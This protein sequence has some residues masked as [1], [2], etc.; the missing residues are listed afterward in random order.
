[1]AQLSRRDFVKIAAGAAAVAGGGALT[2]KLFDKAEKGRPAVEGKKAASNKIDYTRARAIPTVCFGCTTHCGCI[3]WVQD[4]RVRRIDG[5]PFDINTRGKICSKAQ[6]MIQYTYYPER[7]LY[8]I[9]RVGKRGEGKW[10]RISWDEALAEIAGRMK[11]TRESGHPERFIFHYGRDKT[12]GFT[13]RFTNAYGTPNRL[14][15][16]SICSSN[17]RA[18]LMSF[19]GRDFEWETQ[20]FANSKYIVNF[21]GNPMEAYQGGIFMMGRM[22]DAIVDNGCKMVTFE[23]RPSAT[24]SVSTEYYP[25]APGS[26]GAIAA[27]MGNVIIQEG[28]A[29]RKFWDRWA[30]Y[31][32]DKIAAHLEQYTPEWAEK[33]SELP[34]DV[35]RR[36]AIEFARAA[37]AA[38]T[39]SNR[40]SAK[41]YNG[42]Q[43]DRLIRLLDVL[44]GSVGKPGG[45]TLSTVRGWNGKRYGQWGL[46]AVGQP[47]P[48]PPGV[49]A[50]TP[51][52]PQFDDLPQDVKDRWDEFPDKWKKKYVGELATPMDYPLSFHWYGM[53]VGQLVQDYIKRGRHKVEVYMSYVYG[54][55]YGYPEAKVCREVMKDET[56][57][58]FHVAIDIGYGEHSSL[59]DM[60]LPEATSL[61]RWD[62][63]SQNS[64]ALIPY[65]GVRQPLVKP[66]GQARPLQD[67]L[68]ELAVR[69]GGGM[70]KYFDYESTEEFYKAWYKNVP[71][72]WPEFLKRGFWH[73]DTR[74]KDYELYE[75][76]VPEAEMAGAHVDD[77]TG[78]IYKQ[79]KRGREVAIG[80]MMGDRPVRGFPTPTRKIQIYD[81]VWQEAARFVGLPRGDLSG[82]VIPTWMPVPEHLTMRDDQLVFTTFKWNVHTQGRSGGWKY[83]AEIVHTNPVFMHPE[84]GAKLG[85][86]DGDMVQVTTYRPQGFTYRAGETEPVDSFQNRVKFHSGMSKKVVAVSHHGGHWE[87]GAIAQAS[88]GDL[89]DAGKMAAY[90]PALVKDRDIPDNIWWRTDRGGSGNGVCIND[91]IP[92]NPSPM[93]GGQNW[94]DTVCDVK[95][96]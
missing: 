27:A 38:T 24:A 9:R 66:L 64:Y 4:G 85:L 25:V 67:I 62:G 16:R 96:I 88:S 61:E 41:H 83:A 34:A 29:D 12:K 8:P 55:A 18:P 77:S 72:A 58:P 56:L 69:I 90:D 26:D 43:N 11:K 80:L 14:N 78:V 37:P 13:S 68:K 36:V 10:K 79:S 31:S 95:K 42:P 6:G 74:S 3:G 15:R 82:A 1:M 40:G 32:F 70:E 76:P 59:A 30:N 65:T 48:K 71:I 7:L 28:L 93:I 91:A 33:I 22:M 35:I 46:P 5:N 81:P 60:I 2:L 19:Y 50:F 94:M 52:T 47:G 17:R 63:H 86:D 53:K 75:Q 89:K 39:L 45:F 87:H 49:K 20:D 51:G 23:V 73:D 44:V 84:T 54:A 21:G 92:I 57:I